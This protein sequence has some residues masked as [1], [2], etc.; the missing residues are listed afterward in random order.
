VRTG[1]LNRR[2]FLVGAL[3]AAPILVLA[4]ARYLEPKWLKTRRVRLG[5][6]KPSHRFVHITDLHHKGDRALLAAVVRKINALSPDFVC[7]TGDLIE[8]TPFLPEALQLFADI[9]SPVYGVPGNHDY[10]SKAPFD[11]IAK[12][13]ES[14]GGAWLLD[15]QRVTGDGKFS[16]IGATCLSAQQA[17]IPANPSTRNVFLMHYPAWVKRLAGQRYDLML[18]GHSHGGQVRIPLFGAV[19]VPFGVDQYV[20]G[21]FN[22]AAGPL[23]V[24]PG[25][26]WFPV[27]IRFNC[28]PEITVFEM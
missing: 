14:T 11:G 22:T 13:L 3:L 28:R 9:K 4:D 1:K 27:P 24:N 18:A 20:M 6:G 25:I 15:Q 16:I 7:F 26:G 21:L 5:A 8:E 19:I 17:P 23:Y 12:C 10:W 2:R